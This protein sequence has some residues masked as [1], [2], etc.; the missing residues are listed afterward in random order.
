MVRWYMPLAFVF[1]SLPASAMTLTQAIE[2]TLETNPNILAS[3]YNVEAAEDVVRQAQAGY[4]PTL[5]VVLAGGNEV[6]N[7]ATTRATSVDELELHR[8]ER[9]I[10]LTQKLYDG[11]ATQRNVR[12]QR[13]LLDAAAS[14][15]TGTE[16]TTGLRAVQVY[17]EV[18]RREELVSL[19]RDNLD[20][21]DS[22]LSKIRERFESG[23]GT[24]VDVVQTQGRRA[25][26][27]SN[28]LLAQR[29]A[30]NS[31]AQFERVVGEAPRKLELP[32]AVG[33]LPTTL[34]AALEIAWRNNPRLLAAEA[35]LHA[36]EAAQKLARSSFHPRFDL[37]L[38]ATR[39]DDIDGTVGANDDETAVI[40]MTYNLYRGGADRARLNEAESRSFAARENLRAARRAVTE[41]VTLIWNELEDI[42]QRIEH[43]E[44]YVDSTEEVLD[45]YNEQLSLGK[46]SLLDLLDIQ[47]ELL[48]ARAAH[49]SGQYTLRLARY[50]VLAS[51]GQLLDTMDIQSAR[52]E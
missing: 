9:S 6:S 43:L 21:H 16:E 4:L 13:S 27:R 31:E 36:A 34:D 32:E 39:N 11:F 7:N 12:Q 25:Q 14:R 50:R 8:E 38:G 3:K 41:D 1:V 18:L 24:R 46:R 2:T 49:V 40:R 47:N 44:S 10:R 51:L 48:R 26:S 52:A 28:L 22:T 5:D 30:R 45:V 17:L 35:E 33:D 37:Q 29:N 23:V 19:A 15:L 42:K 20:Q